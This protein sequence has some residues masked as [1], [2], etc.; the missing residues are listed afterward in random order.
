M[1]KGEKRLPRTYQDPGVK[2]PFFKSW[3][4]ADVRCEGLLSG[5]VTEVRFRKAS[6]REAHLQTRCR[7]GY[8]FCGVYTAIDRSKRKE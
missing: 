2:C 6:D 7:N 1:P 4:R 5:T 3:G 8:G